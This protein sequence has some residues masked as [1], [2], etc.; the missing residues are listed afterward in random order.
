MKILYFTPFYPPQGEAASTRAY[1]F[2]KVLKEAGH[3]VEVL[4]ASEFTLRPASNKE[5]SIVRLLKENLTGMELFFRVITSQNDM[6]VLSSPPFF[7]VIWGALGAIVSGQKYI[8]DVR[9]MYP[10]IFFELKMI[11]ENS[12]FGFLAKQLTRFLYKKSHTIMTVTHGL[13]RE[14]EKYK[15]ETPH[16]VMNGYDPEIFY[17][18]DQENK[19]QKFTL[20]F[21][22][23]L[24]KVQNIETLLKLAKELESD[25]LEILVA[26]EGPK[27]Q[28]ILNAK[29]PN[30][31]YLGNL[32]YTEIPLILRKCHVGLSFRTDD[33]IGKEAFPVKVFEYVGVGL[34]VIMAPQGEAGGIIEAQSLGQEF[35]NSAVKDMAEAIRNLRRNPFPFKK[36]DSFSRREQ[37]KKILNY[38]N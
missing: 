23:T 36:N 9:D 34:P 37:A 3:S 4:N 14:I 8:L 18:G 7:S 22:G 12:L 5:R 38:L 13:C 17:P 27:A 29:R 24:G 10:E 1:W 26:G 16:L 25:D 20:V 11:R 33:K 2:V 30:I 35:P 28:D 19:F 31:R 32:P 6:I 15:V 21:H